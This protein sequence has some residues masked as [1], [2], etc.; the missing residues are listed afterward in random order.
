MQMVPQGV[1]VGKRSVAP[2]VG[3]IVIDREPGAAPDLVTLASRWVGPARG[4]ASPH[5]HGATGDRPRQP[6]RVLQGAVHH[7]HL[8]WRETRRQ[9]R[10]RGRLAGLA[11]PSRVSATR[12]S[13]SLGGGGDALRGAG[14]TVVCMQ[15]NASPAAAAFIRKHGGQLFVWPTQHRS[16]R[17]V[18]TLL[19]ASTEPPDRALEYRRIQTD[20]FLLFLHPAIRRLP[21][22]LALLVLSPPPSR[23]LPPADLVS[24]GLTPLLTVAVGILV[25][26]WTERSASLAVFAVG[27]VGLVLVADLYNIEN[28][29]YRV[30]VSVPAPA[31]NVIIPGAA[32]LLLGAAYGL[33]ARRARRAR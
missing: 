15:V 20:S 11:L 17:L 9:A 25:L 14:A 4:W 31:I 27:F 29:F 12:G 33:A 23:G 2:A 28:V 21:D 30:G 7:R 16:F 24:R 3:R 22:L 32:L 26:A 6:T 5:R 1:W 19:E 8:L 13:A 10:G 18:L